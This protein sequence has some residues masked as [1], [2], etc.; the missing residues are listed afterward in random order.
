L[1]IDSGALKAPG[2]GC[3]SLI[4]SYSPDPGPPSGSGMFVT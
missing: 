2:S 4:L 3:T 1:D